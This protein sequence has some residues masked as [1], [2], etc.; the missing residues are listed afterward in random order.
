MAR[1]GP[2]DHW[3]P[4]GDLGARVDITVIPGPRGGTLRDRTAPVRSQRAIVSLAAAT[5]AAAALV[6]G[7]SLTGRGGAARPLPTT[8]LPTTV[9]PN[10]VLYPTYL[11]PRGPRTAPS[12]VAPSA[13]AYPLR[14]LSLLIALHDPSLM[15]G[16][17]DRNLP[18]GHARGPYTLIAILAPRSV[19]ARRAHRSARS[20]R[21]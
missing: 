9:L 20:P 12:A 2:D 11:T 14:C 18:C 10:T 6:A 15:N 4:V 17:Y 3:R 19:G 5:L 8:A 1:A 7:I 21:R 16:A 13:A